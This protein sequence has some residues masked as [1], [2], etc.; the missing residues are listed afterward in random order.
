MN[1]PSGQEKDWQFPFNIEYTTK[2]DPRGTVLSDLLGKCGFTGGEKQ[3]L[4]ITYKIKASK[5]Q[6]CFFL[7]IDNF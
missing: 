1:F 2:S 3:N 5:S 6:L 4:D 7:V